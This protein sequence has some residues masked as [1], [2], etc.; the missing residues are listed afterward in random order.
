MC[1]LYHRTVWS[2]HGEMPTNPYKALAR[3]IA[4]EQ[5]TCTLY[6]SATAALLLSTSKK[7]CAY[8]VPTLMLKAGKPFIFVLLA[9]NL[10]TATGTA[11]NTRTQLM[12]RDSDDRSNHLLCFIWLTINLIQSYS[13]HSRY[14]GK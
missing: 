3:T 2:I 11:V 5:G 13:H 4:C 9:K 6:N 8:F 12:M 1:I 7:V 14:I 10:A